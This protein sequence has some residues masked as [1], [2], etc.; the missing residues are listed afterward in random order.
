M[1]KLWVLGSSPRRLTN[2]RHSLLV[3][4]I[5]PELS[6]CFSVW[7]SEGPATERRVRVLPRPA[8]AGRGTARRIAALAGGSAYRGRPKMSWCVYIA[9]CAD[10]SLY[11]GITTDPTARIKRHNAGR[12]S[13]YVRSKGSAVLVYVEP[14]PTKSNA[15]QR[16]LEIKS[17]SR[18][19]KLQLIQPPVVNPRFHG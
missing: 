8:G 12:G 11:T 18:R 17:W 10:D 9:K 5:D 7:L 16:E 14:Q 6:L 2:F 3:A 4:K 15:R 19:K 13:K 1:F